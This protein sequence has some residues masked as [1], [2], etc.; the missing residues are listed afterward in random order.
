MNRL[1]RLATILGLVA[2]GVAAG[3]ILGPILGDITAFYVAIA[4]LIAVAVLIEASVKGLALLSLVAMALMVA[5][6]TRGSADPVPDWYYSSP[7]QQE[8]TLEQ[9]LP[10]A[11]PIEDYE[12]SV[13]DCSELSAYAEWLAENCGY[14]TVIAVVRPWAGEPGHAWVVVEGRALDAQTGVWATRLPAP[15]L[16][17][18]D[19]GEAIDHSA[20]DWDWWV[21][22]PELRR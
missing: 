11:L 1:A 6:A 15:D 10:W 19:V 17:F 3:L 20:A 14:D 21:A 9:W 13:F 2:V 8:G 22:K 16:I 5:I 18:E 4:L 7:C 12:L